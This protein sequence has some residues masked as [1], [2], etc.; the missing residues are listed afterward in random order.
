MHPAQIFNN[1]KIGYKIAFG[2][3]IVGLLFLGVITLYQNTLA[4]TLYTFQTEIL[5]RAEVEKSRATQVNT[6]LLEARRNEKDFF[7]RKEG[8]YLEGVRTLIQALQKQVDEMMQTALANKDESSAK[9]DG[10]IKRLSGEY[11]TAFLQVGQAETEKGLDPQSGLQGIFRQNAH[12]LEKRIKEFDSEEIS[13]D[14]L[15]LRRVEKD[16]LLRKDLKYVMNLEKRM[17]HLLQS[18][19]RSTLSAGAKTQLTKNVELYWT[20]F[21][22]FLQQ[23]ADKGALSDGFREAAQQIEAQLEGLYVPGLAQAYLEIRKDEKD[24][25]LRGDEKYVA[26]VGKRVAQLQQVIQAA[27]IT[28]SEKQSLVETITRYHDAFLA[29][30]AKDQEINTHGVKM[31]AAAH[32]IT[33]IVADLV[34]EASNDMTSTASAAAT[35]SQQ[36]ARFAL[37]VSAVILFLGALLA[38]IIGKGIVDPIHA[39]RTILQAFAEGDLS[40]SSQI[41]QKDE[42][43]AMADALD[44]S[45][46]RLREVIEQ[47]KQSSVEV[48]H[49]GQQLSDAAQSFA[50]NSAEQAAAIEETSS[51]MDLMAHSI[52]QNNQHAV[53]TAQISQHAAQ[54]AVATG[55]SVSQAV[56]AMREIAQKISVI[57]EISRQTN[58]LALNAAI[59]AARAGEHGKG[60]AVVAA[61]VRKLAERSQHAAGEIGTLS[62]SSMQ[63]AEQAGSMLAKLVPEIQKTA[64]LIQGIATASQEQD[65]SATQINSAIQQMDHSIQRNAGTS[66]EMA[67]TS[68]QLSAQ[69]DALQDA[70]AFFKT[71]QGEAVPRSGARVGKRAVQRALPQ[72]QNSAM[73]PAYRA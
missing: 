55:Q 17:Q 43:G 57:E 67:A 4:Q 36:Q 73:L 70:I 6:L 46:I 42:I 16:Y 10:E 38:W 59:E 44:Q 69:A 8:K 15:H 19:E 53:T 30:V 54:D 65:H 68:E 13:L 11:L 33:P 22:H 2:F 48:A 40:I 25:L 45:A 9:M 72:P 47:I 32:A 64:A 62:T 35:A 23:G 26:A 52:Q 1:L 20:E 60:F 12:T 18:I 61:E 27:G 28:A 34:K 21:K 63:V 56:H 49:G 29:L 58:L 41:T 71:G 39:L 5:D 66:E 24:Y 31:R 37:I 50:Q 3:G 7:L 51:S 14:L